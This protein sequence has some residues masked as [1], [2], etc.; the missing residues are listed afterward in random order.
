MMHSISITDRELQVLKLVSLAYSTEEIARELFI[1][2]ETAKTHRK[3]LLIKMEEK[4]A[5]GLVRKA[6]ESGLFTVQRVA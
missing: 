1:G 2:T 5:A 3:N 4:N 6:Y